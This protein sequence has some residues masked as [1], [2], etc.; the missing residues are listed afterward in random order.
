[1]SAFVIN[2]PAVTGDE[3]FSDKAYLDPSIKLFTLKE[4]KKWIFV[5]VFVAL[6]LATGII[7]LVYFLN[8]DSGQSTSPQFKGIVVLYNYVDTITLRCCMLVA[9]HLIEQP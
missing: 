6:L 2:N 1:M 9:Q 8:K 4:K 5:A 7:L 3:T